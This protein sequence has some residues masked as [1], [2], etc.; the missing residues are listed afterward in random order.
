MILNSNHAWLSLVSVMAGAVG[1]STALAMPAVAVEAEASSRTSN[2]VAQ[3][4]VDMQESEAPA[5]I[6]P[7]TEAPAA[8]V[9][10]GATE[11]TSTSISDAELEQ[12]ADTIPQLV[13]IEQA[14]Q[15]QVFQAI[16]E[17]G[18]ERD[19]FYEIYEGVAQPSPD[20]AANSEVTT[21]EQ[22][23]F[24]MALSRIETI[25]QDIRAQQENVIAASGIAPERFDEIMA[26][27]LNDPE[28]QLEVQELMTPQQ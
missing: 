13:A 22:S 19:R 17:S 1:L 18:L 28:L 12:F 6:Q 7:S 14:G 11:S 15:E 16:D 4:E 21:A 9:A 20:V 5:D 3:A 26:A 8:P 24:E 25:E 27:V 2:S 23:S 10:P